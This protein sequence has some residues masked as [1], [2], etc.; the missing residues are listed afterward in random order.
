M[1]RRDCCSQG[2]SART[3]TQSQ[4][5]TH[6]IHH[7]LPSAQGTMRV[8]PVFVVTI[9]LVV[10]SLVFNFLSVFSLRQYNADTSGSRSSS[11]AYLMSLLSSLYSAL[12]VLPCLCIFTVSITACYSQNQPPSHCCMALLH[13]MLWLVSFGS[14]LFLCIL[15]F[16]STVLMSM[17]ASANSD[18]ALPAGFIAA[19]NTINVIL[20]ALVLSFTCM[21][22]SGVCV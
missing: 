11:A 14:L 4:T 19:L 17:E 13:T 2:T 16:S 20:G 10:L 22:F 8:R 6:S 12:L 7:F 9:L 15:P 21:L 1:K 18:T 3:H 5:Y